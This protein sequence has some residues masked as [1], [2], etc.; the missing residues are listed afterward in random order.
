[1]ATATKYNGVMTGEGFAGLVMIRKDQIPGGI[2]SGIAGMPPAM[3]G[4]GWSE[5]STWGSCKLVRA[6][7]GAVTRY[8]KMHYGQYDCCR[9]AEVEL[10]GHATYGVSKASMPIWMRDSL[11]GYWVRTWPKAKV[12]SWTRNSMDTGVCVV[13]CE[14][15]GTRYEIKLERGLTDGSNIVRDL[16]EVWSWVEDM[17]DAA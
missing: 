9:K 7:I 4:E 8:A 5:V 13:E 10:N 6:R 16:S 17:R 1:M 14:E 12:I 11:D 2:L 3:P 15:Y